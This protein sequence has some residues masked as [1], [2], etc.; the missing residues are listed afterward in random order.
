VG[1]AT[2]CLGS[3]AVAGNWHPTEIPE[4]AVPVGIQAGAEVSSAI[5]VIVRV[6]DLVPTALEA[7][8]I[9]DAG[10]SVMATWTVANRG[11]GTA[12][13]SWHDRLYLSTDQELSPG[14]DHYLGDASREAA[15]AAGGSYSASLKFTVP[16]VAP[17]LYYLILQV[18]RYDRVYETDETNNV[19]AKVLGPDPGKQLAL[20][21]LPKSGVTKSTQIRLTTPPATLRLELAVDDHVV[22]T[23]YALPPA[24]GAATALPT[25]ALVM[26][27]AES[28]VA[29]R[30]FD[31]SGNLM[32]SVESAIERWFDGQP[33]QVRID[34]PYLGY[35]ILTDGEV[36]GTQV[37]LVRAYGAYQ[38]L[39]VRENPAGP[40]WISGEEWVPITD[41]TFRLNFYLDSVLVHT[42]TNG[43][44][45]DV[46]TGVWPASESPWRR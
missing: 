20:S 26:A 11:D 29:A 3:V 14:T 39:W 2:L 15:V 19:R 12:R 17:G 10:D 16:T 4:A 18:D 22:G 8:V 33:T 43:L 36:A 25:D 6:P 27:T 28:R 40:G 7:P 1:L 24:G 38:R 31:T 41:G 42:S 13:A 34:E 32:A 30:A 37:V 23:V 35:T 5:A 45:R 46:Q 21:L 44:A 9:V